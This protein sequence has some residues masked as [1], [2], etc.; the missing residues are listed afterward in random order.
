ME[1]TIPRILGSYK[2][3]YAKRAKVSLKKKNSP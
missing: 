3:R 1:F 2:N